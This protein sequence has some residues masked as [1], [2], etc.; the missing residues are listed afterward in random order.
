MTSNVL[1]ASLFSI[2]PSAASQVQPGD[3]LRLAPASAQ[4]AVDGY[5]GSVATPCPRIASTSP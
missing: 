5:G 1:A 2:G 3:S 4:G